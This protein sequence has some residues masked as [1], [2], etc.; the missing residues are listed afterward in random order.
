M[1]TIRLLLAI[2]SS[3]NWHLHQLDVHNAF[4]HGN[5]QEEVFMQLPPGYQPS[6]PNQVRRLLK[7]INGLKQ[8][9]RQWFARLSAALTSKGYIQS[10]SDHSLFTKKS[11]S[12]FTALLFYVDD[13]ILASNDLTEIAAIKSFL[14]TTFKVFLGLE[15]A[16]SKSGIHICQRKYALE[17]LSE[18]GLL[19]AKPVS[20]HMLKGTKLIKEDGPLLDDPTAYRTLI[21]KLLYLKTTRPDIIYVVQQLS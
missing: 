13:L 8:S 20:T 1:T 16:R 4:L 7:S 12:N 3:Q 6:K 11:D 15:I 14:D 17:I 19:A 21:G 2:A 10:A 18:C 9:S 5:L